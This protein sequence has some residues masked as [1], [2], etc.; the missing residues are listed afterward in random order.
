LAVPGHRYR[1]RHPSSVSPSRLRLPLPR[2]VLTPTCASIR[3]TGNR[4][5][6]K[7]LHPSLSGL[8][9]RG[10]GIEG[11]GLA[12]IRRP[13]RPI[14]SST[15]NPVK[16]TNFFPGRSPSFHNWSRCQYAVLYGKHPFETRNVYL[17][18]SPMLNSSLGLH[19]LPSAS[20]PAYLEFI[21]HPWIAVNWMC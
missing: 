2:A 13:S 16:G 5:G 3:I 19:I 17:G 8:G 6:H 15:S 12:T 14:S 10:W 20:N 21:L 9:T 7:E 4:D 18:R 11:D 1:R